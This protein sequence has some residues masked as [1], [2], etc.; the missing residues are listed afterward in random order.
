MVEDILELKSFLLNPKRSD[1]FKTWYYLDGWRMCTIKVGSKKCTVTP[2][3]GRGK[4][5]LTIR[6]LKEELNKLYWYAAKCHASRGKKKRSLR[7]ESDY[8]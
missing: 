1:E 2:L 3:F 8:A 7:W 4:I 5:N 6:T